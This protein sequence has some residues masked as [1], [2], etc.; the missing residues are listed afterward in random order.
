MFDTARALASGLRFPEG[1]SIG[2]DGSVF[3]P[4]IEGR[5]L[6]RVFP[7]GRQETVAEFAGGANGCAFG[8]DGAVYVC[9]NGGFE[10]SGDNGLRYPVSRAEGNTGG[11]LR[12]VDIETG[13]VETVFTE[14]DGERIGG[15]NDIVFDT[16]GSCYVVDTGRGVLYYSAPSLAPSESPPAACISPTAPGSHRTAPACT[17]PRPTPAACA[18]TMSSAPASSSNAPIS[19]SMTAAGT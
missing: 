17:S 19:T 1:A 4:E 7:D 13:A 10:F 16:N 6:A 9:D 8:P 5:A 12:R 14:C 18:P 11:A 15:L 2:A 3:V